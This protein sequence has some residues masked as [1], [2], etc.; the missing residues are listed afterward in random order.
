MH[1]CVVKA[2]WRRRREAKPFLLGMKSETRE[3]K[4]IKHKI[5][6]IYPNFSQKRSWETMS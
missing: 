4:E 5:V 1:S 6:K 2:G 3:G